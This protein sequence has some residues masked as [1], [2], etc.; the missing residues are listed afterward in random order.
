VVFCATAGAIQ[1]PQQTEV[2]AKPDI[3][4]TVGL[5]EPV[6]CRDHGRSAAGLGPRLG[7]VGSALDTLVGSTPAVGSR[8]GGAYGFVFLNSSERAN[9]EH[10][11]GDKPDSQRSSDD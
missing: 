1:P 10:D 4:T 7:V 8:A 11:C 2:S 5:P 6:Q 3:S 9:D